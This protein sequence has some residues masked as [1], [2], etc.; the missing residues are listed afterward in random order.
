MKKKRL[1]RLTGVRPVE[2][3]IALLF[4]ALL[5][6][7]PAS[8]FTADDN[9]FNGITWGT[10]INDVKDMT[11]IR[12]SGDIKIYKKEKEALVI[13]GIETRVGYSFYKDR[14][15][16]G[17]ILCSSSQELLPPV[18]KGLMEKHRGKGEQKEVSELFMEES[19]TYTYL[20]EGASISISYIGSDYKG[21]LSYRYKPIHEEAGRG[22]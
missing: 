8:P 20:W 6:P 10:N 14:F 3:M 19:R 22:R 16:K 4:F 13:P 5:L 18:M 2:V 12:D 21:K 17:A 9:G 1:N 11:L 7:V 15:F